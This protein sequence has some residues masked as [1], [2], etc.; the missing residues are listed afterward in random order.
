M[1][2]FRWGYAS[3]KYREFLKFY[4]A[5]RFKNQWVK[6]PF[7]VIKDTHRTGYKRRTNTEYA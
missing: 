6:I 7:R 5:R 1:F 3:S 2:V 4:T